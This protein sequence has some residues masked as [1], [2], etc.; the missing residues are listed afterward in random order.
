[1]AEEARP[2]SAVVATVHGDPKG[3]R[4]R[5]VVSEKIVEF[6]SARLEGLSFNSMVWFEIPSYGFTHSGCE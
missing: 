3:W 1:V 6:F 2:R 4:N 5:K